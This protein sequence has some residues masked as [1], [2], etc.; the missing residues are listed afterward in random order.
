MTVR[1]LWIPRPVLFKRKGRKGYRSN[2]EEQ[3]GQLPGLQAQGLEEMQPPPVAWCP[4]GELGL[5]GQEGEVSEQVM[6]A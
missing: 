3:G 6:P 1:R 4:Q 2:N 5:L